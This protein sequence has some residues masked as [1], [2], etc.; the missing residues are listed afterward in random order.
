MPASW[1]SG[2]VFISEAGGLRFKFRAHQIGHGVANSSPSLRHFFE[3]SCAARRWASQTRHTLWRNSG[4]T[5][6]DLIN[7]HRRLKLLLTFLDVIYSN[8]RVFSNLVCSQY[9]FSCPRLCFR[10]F[11]P[12][13]FGQ[14]ATLYQILNSSKLASAFQVIIHSRAAIGRKLI[15]KIWSQWFKW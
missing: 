13:I 11:E 12:K 3:K 8:S 2:N 10:V 1:S 6:K 4:S 14:I 9:R 7:S 5:M 15:K